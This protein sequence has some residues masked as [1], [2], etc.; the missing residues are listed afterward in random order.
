MEFDSQDLRFSLEECTEFLHKGMGLDLTPEQI[1]A[2][3]DRTEGWVGLQLVALAL[4]GS[5]RATGLRRCGRS[6]A[7]LGATSLY[8]FFL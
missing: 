3:V 5:P 1:A 6:I 2:L 8:I 4:Q 7:G